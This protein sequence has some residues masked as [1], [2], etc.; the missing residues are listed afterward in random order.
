MTSESLLSFKR[1]HERLPV[2]RMTLH[3][4]ITQKKFPQPVKINTRNYWVASEIDLWVESRAASR[5]DAS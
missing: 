2:S 5:G 1:V 4:W 3:R